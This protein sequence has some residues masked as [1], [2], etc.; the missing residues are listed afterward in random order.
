MEQHHQVAGRPQGPDLAFFQPEALMASPDTAPRLR[1]ACPAGCGVVVLQ[2]TEPI[3]R[4]LNADD[5]L[6]GPT[7]SH[8]L[9]KEELALVLLRWRSRQQSGS[10]SSTASSVLSAG[11]ASAVTLQSGMGPAQGAGGMAGL[12]GL[13]AFATASNVSSPGGSGRISGVAGPNGG[14]GSPQLAQLQ[15]LQAQLQ[16]LQQQSKQQVMVPSL[17]A[18]L[19]HATNGSP[20][21]RAAAP[22]TPR[23]LGSTGGAVGISEIEPAGGAGT[24]SGPAAGALALSPPRPPPLNLAGIG[25][26]TAA[27]ESQP[28]SSRSP[29]GSGGGGA[30]AGT[31]ATGVNDLAAQVAE[32]RRQLGEKGRSPSGGS[33]A[34]AAA[35]ARRSPATSISGGGAALSPS[36]SGGIS[37]GGMGAGMGMTAYSQPLPGFP[38]GQQ[39]QW[40]QQQQAQMFAPFNGHK[41][42]GGGNAPPASRN[43]NQPRIMGGGA[44]PSNPALRK[45]G[46]QNFGS[47]V[48]PVPGGAGPGTGGF[49]GLANLAPQAPAPGP[50]H[51]AAPSQAPAPASQMQPQSQAPFATTS[52]GHSQPNSLLLQQQQLQQQLLLLQQQQK[53]L[54]D[55]TVAKQ[56]QQQK[57]QQRQPASESGSGPSSPFGAAAP[58]SLDSMLG[59]GQT[60]SGNGGGAAATGG[61]SGLP[62]PSAAGGAAI[63]AGDS[64]RSINGSGA[65]T[66]GST[67]GG[68]STGVSRSNSFVAA[69]GTR[70]RPPRQRLPSPLGGNGASSGHV[71]DSYAGPGTSR[72]AA[73]NYRLGSGSGAVG[74]GG[75]DSDGAPSPD[76]SGR[77]GRRSGGPPP[78][79]PS[80]LSTAKSGDD[81]I[82]AALASVSE[83]VGPAAP[84]GAEA[85][86]RGVLGEALGRMEAAAAAAG[87]DGM[88]SSTNSVL[89]ASFALED[90]GGRGSGSGRGS[91]SASGRGSISGG[92]ASSIDLQPSPRTASAVQDAPPLQPSPPPQPPPPRSPSKGRTAMA[93][94]RLSASAATNA[95]DDDE[96]PLAMSAARR[97]QPSS[98]AAGPSDVARGPRGPSGDG[99]ARGAGGGQSGGATHTASRLAA[100]ADNRRYE[101]DHS[102]RS[103]KSDKAGAPPRPPRPPQQPS[104]PPQPPPPP[105]QP[106]AQR[107]RRSPDA[108][109]AASEDSEDLPWWSPA[110]SVG[111]ARGTGDD[112]QV[113]MHSSSGSRMPT[114]DGSLPLAGEDDVVAAV[115]PR[116]AHSPP[117]AATA[118]PGPGPAA[119]PHRALD[120]S[121]SRGSGGRLPSI[122]GAM[123]LPSAGASPSRSGGHPGGMRPVAEP[124]GGSGTTGGASTGPVYSEDVFMPLVAPG[125]GSVSPVPLPPRPST[126]PARRKARILLSSHPIVITREDFLPQDGR[127]ASG[128]GA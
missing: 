48:R 9:R 76:A 34:A 35:A 99:A 60:S 28:G 63:A 74:S 58:M 4:A 101:S 41:V 113:L 62:S 18:G 95:S 61:G 24:A 33:D 104:P 122:D 97:P 126:P 38:M 88:R 21:S 31:A 46:L 16:Q 37:G 43:P 25:G 56:Q 14:G 90:S 7:P 94:H 55:Q 125:L 115:A 30:A 57:Q 27:P 73:S 26:G 45:L 32:L 91:V 8:P 81:A 64:F 127:V 71:S 116:M 44:A 119:A 107:E 111:D 5:F 124:S 79:Q 87:P 82:A 106:P 54:L 59:A 15:A 80:G 98:A 47:M 68:D 39:Q 66:P 92:G 53:Q 78:Q 3:A 10:T 100:A 12:G 128:L 11:S 118:G 20:G 49:P 75:Y 112:A 114:L 103:Q 110:P 120:R 117:Q 51:L 72:F 65:V 19:G 108:D 29:G 93:S 96:A 105:P 83:D 70:Y 1:A 13:A 89:T 109:G 17:G 67:S 77:G 52:A 40:Q 123:P 2:G 6:S 42:S 50:V 102:D 36:N 85:A 23:L 69:G 86:G 121:G 22:A 84:A